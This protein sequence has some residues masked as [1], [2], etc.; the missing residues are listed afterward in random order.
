MTDAF[1]TYNLTHKALTILICASF[2]SLALGT[3]P[4]TICSLATLGVWLFSGVCYRAR[5]DWINQN[6]AIPVLLLMALPW[7]GILWSIA[8]EHKLVFAER[9]YYWLFAFVAASTVTTE[10]NLRRV[11]VCYI[12]GIIITSLPVLLYSFSLLPSMYFMTRT[13]KH[14]YITYSLLIVIAV[15]LL[16]YFFKDSY[17]LRLKTAIFLLIVTLLLTVTRLD[18][19]SGY[20]ALA[21]LSPWIF[22]TML[23]RQRIFIVAAAFM[24]VFVLLSLSPK[25]RERIALIPKEIKQYQSGDQAKTSSVGERLEMWRDAWGIFINNP[26]AGAGTAGFLH[27]S[28]KRHPGRGAS[29]PHNSYLFIAANYGILGILVYGWLAVLTI[30]RAW[31]TRH[32]LQGHTILAFI[33]VI[34]IGSLTDTTILS[35]ATGIALGFIIGI[36]TPPATRCVS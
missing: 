15:V 14:G 36:P 27:E 2:F 24:T 30:R 33:S 12:A 21:L 1:K 10:Q 3:A 4:L 17:D 22:I 16:A 11:T 8:P 13:V 7:L 9:S 31:Q 26:V 29:H 5:Q 28:G 6:W 32:T 20:L 23:G 19:R 18:G 35:V 25:V 34:L